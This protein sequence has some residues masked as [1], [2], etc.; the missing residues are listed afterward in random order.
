V[1]NNNNNNNN[2]ANMHPTVEQVSQSLPLQPY[3]SA[4]SSIVSINDN[5][6]EGHTFEVT[7]RRNSLGLGLSI[8]GGPEAPYPYNNLI[9]VKKIFPLQPAWETGQFQEGDILISAGGKNL[10]GLGLRQALDVLRS[11]PPLTTICGCRPL[12]DIP[13]HERYVLLYHIVRN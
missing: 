4:N 1:N 8:T 6:I 7:L 10:S 11:S 13:I 9:R 12:Q 2:K 5:F 3:N